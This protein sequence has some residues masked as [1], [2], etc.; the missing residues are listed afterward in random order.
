MDTL[1]ELIRLATQAN[2]M[3]TI[4]L[5]ATYFILQGKTPAS[6]TGQ[7]MLLGIAGDRVKVKIKDEEHVIRFID[8]RSIHFKATEA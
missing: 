1:H 7:A 4:E 5:P 8:V 6:A 3:A 2:L